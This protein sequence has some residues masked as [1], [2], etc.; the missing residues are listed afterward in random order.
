MNWHESRSVPAVST[1][2]DAVH[3]ISGELDSDTRN[4]KLCYPKPY[5]VDPPDLPASFAQFRIFGSENGLLEEVS[6]LS[7]IA[8]FS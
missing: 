1:G 5:D 6:F 7:L 4:F 8:Q 2:P 3:V